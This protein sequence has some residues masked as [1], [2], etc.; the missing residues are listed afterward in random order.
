[1]GKWNLITYRPEEIE[2]MADSLVIPP[3]VSRA[4]RGL[5]ASDTTYPP[6]TIFKFSSYSL[7]APSS[8]SHLI[9]D[10]C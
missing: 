4:L 5:Y 10:G 2:N 7:L 9:I 8:T 3:E 1:M 6:D